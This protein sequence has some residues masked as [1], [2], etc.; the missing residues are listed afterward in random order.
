MPCYEINTFRVEFKAENYGLLQKAVQGLGGSI[1]R[2]ATTGRATVVL[3]DGTTISIENG[4][5]TTTARN[6]EQRIN[7][8]RVAYSQTVVSQAKQ[9]A[10]SKGWSVQQTSANKMTLSKGQR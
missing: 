4:Q 1:M 7:E 9:W 3:K 6:G 10:A 5:A 2:N 8:L